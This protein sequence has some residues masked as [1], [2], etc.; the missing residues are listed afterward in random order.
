[1]AWMKAIGERTDPPDK[2]GFIYMLAGDT[3]TT[4]HHPHQKDTHQHWVQTPR[5]CRGPSP[6]PSGRWVVPPAGIPGTEGS[7]SL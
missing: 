1:M 2:I 6:L 4:N 3:G 5:H 7:I